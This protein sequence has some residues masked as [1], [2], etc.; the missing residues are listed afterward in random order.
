MGDCVDF[1]VLGRVVVVVV[2]VVVFVVLGV[3]VVVVRTVLDGPN[4]API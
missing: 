1:V 4:A 2:V 3:V